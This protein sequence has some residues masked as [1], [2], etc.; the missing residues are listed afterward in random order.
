MSKEVTYLEKTLS[1]N[2]KILCTAETHWMIYCLD[3]F[4]IIVGI[5]FLPLAIIPSGVVWGISGGITFW[6][7][8]LIT[9]LGDYKKEMIIT[10]RRV[11]IK[12]GLITVTT[13]ELLNSKIESVSFCQG[14]LG[15]L[16]GY[17]SIYFSGTGTTKL[18]SDFIKKPL[19][20]KQEFEDII[21]KS[22]E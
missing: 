15:S 14:I 13:S 5:L 2:E 7:I 6:L 11:I 19:S 18:V 12:K 17:G 4:F 21:E 20:V 16:L 9:F 10:N 3:V 8:A 22:K 1:K